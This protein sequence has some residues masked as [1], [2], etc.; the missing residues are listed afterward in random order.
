MIN[1]LAIAHNSLADLNANALSFFRNWKKFSHTRSCPN[2]TAHPNTA[3]ELAY[4]NETNCKLL[5]HLP[6]PFSM[7]AIKSIYQ[8]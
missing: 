2:P 1:Y 5:I 7:Y 4:I 6:Q 3:N 8:Y